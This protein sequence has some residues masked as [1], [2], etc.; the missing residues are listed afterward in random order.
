[1]L[2][3]TID[4]EFSEISQ[5]TRIASLLFQI[6]QLRLQNRVLLKKNNSLEKDLW[7]QELQIKQLTHYLSS[8]NSEFDEEME[9]AKKIQEGLMPKTLPEMI[10]IDSAAVYIP[11]SKVGGDLYD[12]MITPSQ[13]TAVLIFDVSGHGIPAALVG[14][15]AKMLFAHFIEKTES[16]AEVFRLINKQ[17]CSFIK[18]EQYLTAFLGIIDP[19]KNIMTYSRAGHVPPLVYRKNEQKIISLDSRGF[20]I[21]HSALENL[22]EYWEQTINL[23]PGDKILFYTDGLT[24][25]RNPQGVLYGNERLKAVYSSCAENNLDSILDN[26]VSDQTSFRRGMPLRDDFTLLCIELGNSESLLKDSGFTPEDQPEIR[27]LNSHTEIEKTCDLILKEM[28]KR[29]FSEKCIKQ[30]KL[31]IYE[32]ITNALLHGNRGD[33]SK[34]V[35]VFYQIT[36]FAATISVLDEGEGF[37][38]NDIPNPLLPENRIKDHGRGLFLI[39]RYLDEVTFNERGNRIT[40]RKYYSGK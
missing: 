9:T 11:A 12:I 23:E 29:G 38:Y 37:N 1:M 26:I 36:L 19:V 16:P 32:M 3:K 6:R 8:I 28:D 17:I 10:N 15:M 13:K 34:K 14:A 30:F 33:T 35:I 27:I 24:E 25:G 20:F 18:T 21:G 7:Q 4:T 2:E 40:G 5:R 31:C 39:R 22:A